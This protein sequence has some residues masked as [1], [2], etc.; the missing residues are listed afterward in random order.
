MPQSIQ[1]KL[2]LDTAHFIEQHPHLWTSGARCRN[3]DGKPVP[4]DNPDVTQRCGVSW[5]HQLG[6]ER[7][8]SRAAVYEMFEGCEP[9]AVRTNDTDGLLAVAKLFRTLAWLPDHEK[10]C[11]RRPDMP[12]MMRWR[13]AVE[14]KPPP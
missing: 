3:A 5:L 7:G 6:I 10:L 14:T 12:R 9:C 13:K 4:C 11:R 2:L 8:L 1:A